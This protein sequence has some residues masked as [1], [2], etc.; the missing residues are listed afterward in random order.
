MIKCEEIIDLKNKAWEKLKA[1]R[2]WYLI[3][4]TFEYKN[5]RDSCYYNQSYTYKSYY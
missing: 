1:C 3:D 4:S 2:Q 5:I